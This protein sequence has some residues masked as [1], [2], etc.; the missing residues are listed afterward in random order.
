MSWTNLYV[1]WRFYPNQ[2]KS[3]VKFPVFQYLTNIWCV[4]AKQRIRDYAGY[5][6]Q[7][8]YWNALYY[9]Q[10]AQNVDISVISFWALSGDHGF[11]QCSGRIAERGAEWKVF[12]PSSTLILVFS[13]TLTHTQTHKFFKADVTTL[14]GLQILP[15]VCLSLSTTTW[16]KTPQQPRLFP[17]QTPTLFF[18]KWQR[19][20]RLWAAGLLDAADPGHKATPRFLLSLLH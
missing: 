18:E 3:E 20:N 16:A 11:P 14:S 1:K 7:D 2:C 4:D 19:A 8:R 6:L 5:Y 9:R 10:P 12:P 15:L 13:Q 17:L